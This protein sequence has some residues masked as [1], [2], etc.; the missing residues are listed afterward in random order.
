MPSFPALRH[1]EFAPAC[2]CPC[3]RPHAQSA[4]VWG[5]SAC[6]RVQQCAALPPEAAAM[7]AAAACMGA[8]HFALPF[9]RKQ[10]Q[11]GSSQW[12]T[13]ARWGRSSLV[14]Y[15][16]LSEVATMCCSFPGTSGAQGV[17][18]TMTLTV[19]AIRMEKKPVHETPPSA[20]STLP[21]TPPAPPLP[22]SS[23]GL[24]CGA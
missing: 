15:I 8:Q 1:A 9:G 18:R 10:L 22:L 24:H 23:M 21:P 12:G 6:V 16:S 7:S 20:H 3:S 5:T 19:Q 2:A 17:A 11:C 4:A 14:G 13:V